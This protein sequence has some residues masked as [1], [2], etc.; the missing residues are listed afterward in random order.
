MSESTA[1]SLNYKR[2]RTTGIINIAIGTLSFLVSL[3]Q[4]GGT[5]T[6]II[7]AVI[8]ALTVIAGL[9][10]VLVPIPRTFRAFGFLF[11]AAGLWHLAVALSRGTSALAIGVLG[12]FQIVWSLQWFVQ[13]RRG[14]GK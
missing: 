5:A 7:P 9:R 3:S 14:T 4:L 2:L 8:S 13:W 10:A 12:L 11:L 6:Y 1:Q